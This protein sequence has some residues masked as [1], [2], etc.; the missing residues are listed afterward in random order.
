MGNVETVADV[1]RA[2]S[3]SLL[4]LGWVELPGFGLAFQRVGRA[5]LSSLPVL[6]D[7]SDQ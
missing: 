2:W 7:L 1:V 5:E 3:S 4:L 6:F